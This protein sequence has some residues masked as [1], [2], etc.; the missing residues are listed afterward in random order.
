MFAE[1][2]IQISSDGEKYL[3]AAIGSPIF[4]ESYLKKKVEK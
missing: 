1:T 4:R 2:N 3:G